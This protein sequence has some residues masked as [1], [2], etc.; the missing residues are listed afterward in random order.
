MARQIG[1]STDDTGSAGPTMRMT[2]HGDLT[3]R[4]TMKKTIKYIAPVL[5]ATGIVASSLAPVGSAAAG[6]T[7]AAHS[8]DAPSSPSAPEPY[9]SEMGP[10]VPGGV[11]R[12]L[13]YFPGMISLVS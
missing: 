11:H 4:G 2:E 7:P 5:A 13:P 1:V 3:N 8:T 6:S 10:L 9:V 12:Y